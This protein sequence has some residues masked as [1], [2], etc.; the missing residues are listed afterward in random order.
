[1]LIGI[2]Q[3]GHFP[4]ELVGRFGDYDAMF[5]RLLSGQGFDFATWQVV[6]GAFPP[7]PEAADGWIV[8]GSRHGVYEAHP[9]IPPLETFLR[10]AHEAG[11]P[12]VGICFG[13][14]I[15]AQAMGGRVEKHAGGWR[16][17]R[18]M[19]RIEG[20]ERP[21]ALNAWHQDQVVEVPPGA[22]VIGTA[23]GCAVAALAYGDRALSFQPHPEFD[24]GEVAGLIE[25]RG[26][27][28][29]PEERLAPARAALGAPL[30]R[31]AIAARIAAFFRS[32][33]T[34]EGGA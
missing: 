18:G 5:H 13:H 8:T 12:V 22:R 23:E 1:M 21:L 15:L 29:V 4:A 27:G 20:F 2:L 11:R 9:W 32:G 19:Y 25:A 6:D 14:Q 24:H 33:R 10:S 28:S 34:G 30:D 31:D 7:G 17:G 26:T 16:V 3:T